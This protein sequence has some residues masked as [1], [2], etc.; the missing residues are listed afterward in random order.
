M[1]QAE[2]DLNGGV[3]IVKIGG[4]P[5]ETVIDKQGI[6][7]FKTDRLINSLYEIGSIDLNQLAVQ[8]QR[9]AFTQEEYLRFY[10]GIGCSVTGLYDLPFFLDLEIENPLW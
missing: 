9:G 5:F 10:T 6:Q 7:R 2:V 8:Y 4:K 1:G 3:T